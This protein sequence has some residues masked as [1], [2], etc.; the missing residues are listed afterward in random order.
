MAATD[1]VTVASEDQSKTA[2]RPE[3]VAVNWW[4]GHGAS[5]VI[6]GILDDT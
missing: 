5:L 3:P 2:T 4:F 6:G 1:A